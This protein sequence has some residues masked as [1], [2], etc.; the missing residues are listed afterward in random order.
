MIKFFR[1]IFNEVNDGKFEK[2][3]R[4]NTYSGET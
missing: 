3:R 4:M 2:K 1:I